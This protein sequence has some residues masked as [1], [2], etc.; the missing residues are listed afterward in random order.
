[1]LYIECKAGA[2]GDMIMGA[3]F[4]ICSEKDKFI[5]LMNGCGIT[6]VR[7]SAEKSVKCGISGTKM[8][9]LI[10]GDEEFPA[11]GHFHEHDHKDSHA[12]DDSHENHHEHSHDDSHENHHEHS[13]DDS[14]KNHNEKHHSHG[15]GME[16]ICSLITG[17][18]LDERVKD[19][20]IN[21]YKIIAE[22]EAKVHGSD[23]EHIHFH[24][25]GTLDA[26]ADVVG[27]SL[28][29]H[30]I[31][32]DK[33][34]V[35]PINTGGGY[36]KCAHGLL[37]V[38]APATAEI[39][40]GIPAYDSGADCELC[41]PTGAA[42]LKY[43]ADSFGARPIMSINKIGSGMGTRELEFANCVRVFSANEYGRDGDKVLVISANVDDMTGEQL[44]FAREIFEDN[45]AL[46]VTVIPVY[47][48]KNRPGIIIQCV[49]RPEDED[50]FTRLFFR[51]TSTRGVRYSFCR[52]SMMKS[53]FYD[54]DTEYGRIR[55]KT[56][57][58][59]DIKKSKPEYESVKAAALKKGVSPDEI[60][61]SIREAT[62]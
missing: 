22:A 25:V 35:S 2:A 19:D 36:V 56:N 60:I 54:A 14:H 50:L 34:I 61:K 28:L 40:K 16:G 21:I 17:L 59:C 42:V 58:Y 1:M 27:C 44:G 23:I 5:E 38:P 53:G 57:T 11:G 6:G 32:P 12:H 43:F 49:C 55:I 29:I 9:V 37:P 10:N 33:I 3:L 4:E 13:H 46:D 18:R 8:R 20:A 15:M 47:M 45:G 48:K 39:L 26:V 41:T 52:R 7:V 62:E 31:N 24:E 30:M 51:Y